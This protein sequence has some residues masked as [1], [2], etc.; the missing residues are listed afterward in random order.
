MQKGN[1]R[2]GGK[3]RISLV[4]QFTTYRLCHQHLNENV[5]QKSK[6]ISGWE[7]DR[8]R[9]RANAF[10]EM[11]D[12]CTGLRRAPQIKLREDER[13]GEQGFP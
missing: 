12:G 3:C 10:A 1:K 5:N 8:E 4:F 7:A 9:E 11:Q 2:E 13:R 6:G